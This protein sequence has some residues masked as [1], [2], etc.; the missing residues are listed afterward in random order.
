VEKTGVTSK[1]VLIL[2]EL[3]IILGL[4]IVNGVFAGSEIAVVALRKT[5]LAELLEQG[6]SSA[7]AVLVLKQNPERFLATVQIGITV[8]SATAA[9]F[10]GASIAGRLS[11]VLAQI[12]WLARHADSVA[13]AIVVIIVSYL[14]IVLGELVPK[15]L[16]LRAAESYA[17]LISK[18]LVWLAWLARPLVWL[19]TASSN[20][21][22]KPFGDRTTFTEARHSAEELQ[23]LVEEAASVGTVHPHAGEIA[24]R[25]LDFSQLTAADVMVPRT[26]IVMLRRN[27]T[28]EETH[29]LILEHRH[30]RMPVYEGSID[31][32][33][34]Y[35]VVRD[36]LRLAWKQEHVPLES[37]IRSCYFVPESKSAVDLL[38][39]LRKKRAP[40]A[41]VVDEQGG[42]AGIITL[43]DLVEELV[44]E[45]LD[46][47]EDEPAEIAT[48]QPD[49]SFVTSG[50]AT[51]R[52]L[53]RALSLDLPEDGDWTT[54][55][56]LCLALAGRIP[57]SG[58]SLSLPS[59]V[60]LEIVDAS[61]RKIRKVRVCRTSYQSA[62]D[63]DV[64]GAP[65]P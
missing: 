10:G 46:E 25:A 39:E 21:V 26:N 28:L 19:L 51:V 18:P 64:G 29:R 55:A 49:G 27:A 47:Y 57:K 61:Q 33:I 58:E 12:P 16:A 23:Q 37:I 31:N 62:S 34:G 48:K 32:V 41:I 42:M 13:L 53:N 9:A 14:S 35:V 63:T 50:A 30:A 7:N 52:D 6:R 65:A 40:L 24:S 59:G 60:V 8:V 11:P 22:L 45:I 38:Q 36:F 5:R 17:L 1:G 43:E 20:I 56:G 44:G 2:V 4:I 54:V 3:I 15:S